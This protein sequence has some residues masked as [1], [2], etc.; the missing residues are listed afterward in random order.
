MPYGEVVEQ[1]TTTCGHCQKLCLVRAG[2]DGTGDGLSGPLPGLAPRERPGTHVC[3]ICW[4]IVCDSCHAKGICSPW[5]E[6][7]KKIEARDRFL[8]SAGLLETAF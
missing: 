3:H 8:R 2:G 5:E 6:R 1:K 7:L 4:R